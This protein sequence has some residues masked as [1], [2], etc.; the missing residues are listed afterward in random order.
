[1]KLTAAQ[2]QAVSRRDGDLLVSASAGAGKTEVLA[3]RCVALVTDPQQPAEVTELLVV[4][5]TRAAARELRSRIARML[6]SAAAD[7][8]GPRRNFLQRQAALVEAADIGT[9]DAWCGRIVREHFSEAGV[10]PAFRVLA[11]YEAAALLEGCLDELFQALY[12]GE[13]PLAVATRAWLAAERALDDRGLRRLVLTLHR[14][15]EHLVWPAPWFERQAA[16]LEGEAAELAARHAERVRNAVA[17]EARYQLAELEGVA[18][19]APAETA[20]W[21]ATVKE[22]LEAC[23]DAAAGGGGLDEL[24]EQVDQVV[25][26]LPRKLAPEAKAV[27]EEVSQRWLEERLK[28]RWG[29]EI[30]ATLASSVVPI[31]GHLRTLT[32]LAQRYHE[33][34]QARKHALAAYEFGDIQRFTLNLLATP[35]TDGGL[36]PTPLAGAIGA[37]YREVLV[38]EYQ[39]TSPIQVALL[40]AIAQGRGGRRFLVGDV[41][42]S[43]YG[44]RE[45]E[46]RLF[47]HELE[48]LRAP[49][50][51]GV[52]FL[53]ENFRS[54][55]GVLAPLNTLFAR[56]FAGGFGGTPFGPEERLVAARAAAEQPNPSLDDRPRCRL[57]VLEAES[58]RRS[59]DNDDPDA[60]EPERIEREATLVA[61]EIHTLREQDTQI[62]AADGAGRRPLALGDIVILLRSAQ[63]NA[64]RVAS[65][66]RGQGIPA[67]AG[68]RERLFDAL[69]VQDVANVLAL[70]LQRR[71]DLRLAAYLR[72]PLVGLDAAELL[73]IR[74][75]QRDADFAAAV[76]EYQLS[77]PDE[78]LRSQLASAFA[79]LDR[80]EQA[81]RVTTLE[82][83]VRQIIRESDLRRVAAALHGGAQRVAA[84]D[85]LTQY[86]QEFAG[87]GGAVGEF[88]QHL[89]ELARHGLDPGVGA[90]GAPDAV[91]VLT[92]HAA[93]GLEFPV[94]FLLNTGAPFNRQVVGEPLQCDETLGLGL[95][96]FDYPQR[97]ELRDVTS[98]EVRYARYAKE[99]EE[100]LRLL[101]VAA[102]RARELLYFVGHSEPGRAALLAELYAGRGLPLVARQ[103]ARG[104][105]DWL[106][107]AAPAVLA[108]ASGG[109]LLLEMRVTKAAAV[110]PADTPPRDDAV[111]PPL[112]PADEQWVAV[113][114]DAIAADPPTGVQVPA[115][116]SVSA[117]KQ[118]AG[119]AVPTEPT[120]TAAPRLSTPRFVTKAEPSG[121][122]RGTATHRFLQHV[123]LEALADPEALQRERARLV[124]AG[125]LDATA[126]ESVEL[127]DLAWFGSTPLGLALRATPERVMR[128]LAF[129]YAWPVGGDDTTLLRGVI[130]GLIA[131][132][133][134]LTLIDYKTD[135]LANE[136]ALKRRVAG[137]AIQVRAYAQ[138]AAAVLGR[139]VTAAHLVFLSHRQTVPVNLAPVPVPDLLQHLGAQPA[140]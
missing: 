88:V 119:R 39:D 11:E 13:E 34:V 66:L 19:A 122:D 31:T 33:L 28:K 48:R 63:Q 79:Q 94:V 134:G 26:A 76:Q 32:A 44:F 43:I 133:D 30:L 138:A 105:L 17:T 87:G 139:P 112:S 108:D 67:V 77:G 50:R 118:L 57:H 73:A 65:V 125:A 115:A 4:T 8:S 25:V 99:I 116:L 117:L 136:A 9:I 103:A 101:Y 131:G 12:G 16:R 69:E 81:A 37:R 45:A 64:G 46:P 137:Y 7:A 1:M 60:L 80:W 97:R 41:K 109:Q 123:A 121:T 92:V 120:A 85:A 40:N 90:V 132:D 93:K 61:R 22:R 55:A 95:R 3:R 70:L 54:H 104:T 113:A 126:A 114:V 82:G 83:L 52:C 110:A 135:R 86:C 100:E 20:E 59:R 15:R 129:V 5:F 96:C 91:R 38:D 128:E 72:S 35:T 127:A 42:Q 140:D 71:Q 49:D 21:F 68:G 74:Q 51:D 106:L 18:P 23:A 75:Q 10:D 24:G 58:R 78:R 56:L 102:T 84:L 124:A 107:M 27:C 29:S 14:F 6:R 36:A 53:A 47:S 111:P 89:D 2:Q 62:P 130:D 98:Q